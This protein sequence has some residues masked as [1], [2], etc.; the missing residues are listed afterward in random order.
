MAAQDSQKTFFRV[1]VVED[2]PLIRESI[3]VAVGRLANQYKEQNWRFEVMQANDGGKAMELLQT[4]QFDLVV[5]DLYLPVVSG[6]DIIHK[7]RSTAESR[8]TPILAMSAS[9]ED[10]RVRSL[11]AGADMFLQKPLRLVDVLEALKSLLKLG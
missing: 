1:L 3:E 4:Y 9:I 7:L 10:A 8:A 6:L 2:N 5:V 11:S